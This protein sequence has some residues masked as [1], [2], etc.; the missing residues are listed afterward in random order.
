[1]ATQ[2]II[3][4]INQLR[5]KKKILIISV[6]IIFAIIPLVFYIQAYIETV[7]IGKD[8]LGES[9]YNKRITDAGKYALVMAG[10]FSI[11]LA[12]ALIII[13]RFIN[14]YIRI[15][16]SLDEC[17][18]LKLKEYNDVQ[19]SLN[20][21]T[22]PFIFEKNTLHIFKLGKV[23]SIRGSNIV[24]YAI[25]KI[26]SRGRVFYRLDI[27]T[28]NGKYHYMM[29]NIDKQAK[30]LQQDIASIMYKKNC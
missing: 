10:I 20:K 14:N 5:L 1:M 15:L 16:K 25:E 28:R 19:L 4:F 27:N 12:L 13:N 26:Y 30:M 29:Y 2:Y 22:V 7:N 11:F 17:D 24:N 8:L 21:Y 6:S 18:I 23:T 9:Q 3:N